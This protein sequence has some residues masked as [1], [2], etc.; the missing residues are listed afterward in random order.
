MMRLPVVLLLV[1]L[2]PLTASAQLMRDHD[3][4]GGVRGFHGPASVG[5]IKRSFQS[6][7][8]ARAEFERIL[9]AIGLTWITDRVAL[10]ASAETDNAE[11]GI[12]KNGDR[13]IF[14]N[15]IFM[16]KLRQRTAADWS[17]VSILAHEL[18]HHLAFHT[19][20][21]G[22]WHEFE[23]EADYFSGFVLRRLGAT[24]DQ[25]QA[26]MRAISPK[27]ASETHPGLDQR[28]QAITIGWTDGGAQGAPRGLKKADEKATLAAPPATKPELPPT[29]ASRLDIVRLW[30]AGRLAGLLV[31]LDYGQAPIDQ[32]AGRELARLLREFGGRIVP[33]GPA[34][35]TVRQRAVVRRSEGLGKRMADVTI[36]LEC[37][38][39]ASNTRCSAPF[40][41]TGSGEGPNFEIAI[42]RALRKALDVLEPWLRGTSAVSRP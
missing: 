31:H 15:A 30:Q 16:Q 12:G 33:G 8:E 9:S 1:A 32:Q 42:E 13:F 34:D 35:V 17:L 24:L 22:R 36:N 40:A 29:P 23:L 7:G 25:A 14:Y 21:D 2:L 11:A 19:E 20:T 27:Q 26:A 18:G 5:R 41:A 6:D 39:S 38:V 4:E 28:L 37:F 3:G 10:R